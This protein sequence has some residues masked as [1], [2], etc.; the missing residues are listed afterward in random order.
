M[1]TYVD[2]SLHTLDP[3]WLR[4]SDYACFSIRT[5]LLPRKGL[6]LPV[7]IIYPY[8]RE[9][10]TQVHRSSAGFSC[11]AFGGLVCCELRAAVAR[12]GML[13]EIR[14]SR[15]RY[16][17]MGRCELWYNDVTVTDY[18]LALEGTEPGLS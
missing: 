5:Y 12:V 16:R 2:L 1:I 8:G 9:K 3:S 14:M 7:R 13:R 18:I 4:R 15:G 10:R 17:M 11:F 6:R